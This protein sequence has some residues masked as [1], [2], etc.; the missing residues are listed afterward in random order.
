MMSF[1]T[2]HKNSDWKKHTY[3]ALCGLSEQALFKTLECNQRL[4]HIVLCL[5]HDSAGIEVSEK[6]KDLLSGKG[7]SYSQSQSH[8]KD[9]NEDLKA[10]HNLNPI[11]SEEHPQH[12]IKND[13]CEE[14]H[15]LVNEIE[16]ANLQYTNGEKALRQAQ[17][18]NENQ[19]EAMKMA[20]AVFLCLSLR[21]R[22]QIGS[23]LT[24][25]EIVQ[26]LSE[27]FRAYQNRGRWDPTLYEVKE[28]F[29]SIEKAKGIITES[30]IM[31]IA[32]G[33]HEVALELL[34]SMI[35]LELAEQKQMQTQALKMA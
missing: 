1:I 28:K 2:Q 12:L 29:A 5:D 17:K 7:L 35:K 33:Y 16:S 15:L 4:S 13:L 22:R 10:I 9:W 18:Q 24:T 6:I 20:S 30:E 14:L 11:P 34:K 19:A 32:N 21:E 26:N 3:L 27:Q 8:Y 31:N 23:K 25:E